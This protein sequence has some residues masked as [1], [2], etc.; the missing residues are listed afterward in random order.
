MSTPQEDP[1]QVGTIK[2]DGEWTYRHQYE[3][4]LW[5]MDVACPSQEA[6]LFFNGQDVYASFDG[7]VTDCCFTS[8]L[9]GLYHATEESKKRDAERVG[10][11]DKG[12]RRI[13]LSAVAPLIAEDQ[14]LVFDADSKSDAKFTLQLDERFAKMISHELH[15]YDSTEWSAQAGKSVPVVK[16]LV[17]PSVDGIKVDT[18]HGS[19][20]NGPIKDAVRS[21]LSP[22]PEM[23]ALQETSAAVL[24][25]DDP[26][27]DR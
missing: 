14:P 11:P 27:L 2:L 3:T 22:R 1:I 19:R 9:G 15:P 17:L 12:S 5:F 16:H 20:R 6:P 26:Q 13:P 23:G 18:S 24:S 10:R 4:A 7:T 8:G 21:A 25:H